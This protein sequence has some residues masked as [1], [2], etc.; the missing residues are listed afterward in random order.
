MFK[1]I[2]IL[3]G[4]IC[5]ATV[6]FL[7][8]KNQAQTK[9]QSTQNVDALIERLKEARAQAIID[10]VIAM[11]N[12]IKTQRDALL[13]SASG[14]FS[15]EQKIRNTD[16]EIRKIKV[17]N[18]ITALEDQIKI[19]ENDLNVLSARVYM[20]ATPQYTELNTLIK[21]ILEDSTIAAYATEIRMLKTKIATRMNDDLVKIQEL[22][23]KIHDLTKKT[24]QIELN[25]LKIKLELQ[26]Q[27]VQSMLLTQKVTEE[28]DRHVA[29]KNNYQREIQQKIETLSTNDKIKIREL[30]SAISR[31][32]LMLNAIQDPHRIETISA[33]TIIEAMA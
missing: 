15:I 13:R 25:K 23:K 8:N 9:A 14:V 33:D 31:L 32:Q 21:N 22:G 12:I 16:E 6:V 27:Q 24:S 7:Y 18:N 28:L 3:I 19:T 2:L 29:E 4:T 17:K 1:K 30:Q 11:I 26:K 10:R 5:L 20:E